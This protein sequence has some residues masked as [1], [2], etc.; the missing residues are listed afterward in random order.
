MLQPSAIDRALVVTAHPDDVDFG[1]AGTV[2]TLTDAGAVVTYC[3]VTDGD[4]GGHDRSVSRIDMAATRRREQWA[5]AEKVGVSDLIWLSR[6]DGR[7]VAD[8]ALREAITRVIREV[9][10]NLVITQSPERNLDRII[11][12]HPDHLATGEATICAVYPDSRNPF[13]YPALLQDEGL[14]P[15]TVPEMWIMAGP[16]GARGPSVEAVD[17]TAQIDRKLAALSCHVSQHQDPERLLGFVRQRMAET[18]T[19]FELGEGALAEVFR[20]VNTA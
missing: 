8:L 12:S 5:A 18:A 10:P 9:R 17:V 4:A 1:A 16:G 7:V 14:E 2:A 19:E 13:S 15:W 3:L 6:P 20:I 11:G